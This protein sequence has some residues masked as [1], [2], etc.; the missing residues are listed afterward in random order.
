MNEPNQNKSADPG[1]YQS[2]EA[3]EKGLDSHI[4]KP[5]TPAPQGT[6]LDSLMVTQSPKGGTPSSAEPPSAPTAPTGSTD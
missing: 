4:A 2:R 1:A 5:F 3:I 6:T